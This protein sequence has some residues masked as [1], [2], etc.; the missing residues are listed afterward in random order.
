[1]KENII[2]RKTYKRIK[3]M[4]RQEMEKFLIE[5]YRN[6]FKDGTESSNNADF[7][8]RLS[9]ILQETKGVGDKLYDRIM[10][11]AKEVE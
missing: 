3:K 1:M 6:G 10:T 8:I 5:T 7:R 11:K 2:N 9:E 4:D